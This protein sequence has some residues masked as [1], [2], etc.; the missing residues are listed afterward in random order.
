MV[1]LPDPLVLIRG[2]DFNKS[3]Q[4]F[5]LKCQNLV[6]WWFGLEARNLKPSG[7]C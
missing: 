4:N 6:W 5:R 7:R 3:P 2:A 1:S